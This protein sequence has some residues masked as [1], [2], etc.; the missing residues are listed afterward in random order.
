MYEL[1]DHTADL[2]LRVIAPDRE[3]LWC[4]A[5]LGLFSVIVEADA[6]LARPRQLA[7]AL[8]A[9]REDYLLVDWLTELLYVFERE[10]VVLGDFAV[11]LDGLSLSATASGRPLDSRVDRLSHEVK[12]VTYHG[13]RLEQ[14]P[15]GW[16]A[17]VILDI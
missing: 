15:Q 16:L 6:A 12:A 5:A 2:G 7:F 14:V 4:E 8:E 17:E 1:F 9:A 3:T 10:R 13:L 11:R